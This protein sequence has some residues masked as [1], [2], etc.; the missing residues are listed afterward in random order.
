ME[1]D[2]SRWA[3]CDARAGFP[4]RFPFRLGR[5]SRPLLLLFGVR[6]SNAYVDLDTDIDARFGFYRL[7]TPVSNVTRYRIEGP[8]HWLTA[9][10]V[11]RGIRHGDIS[12]GGTH[13]G[14]FRLD[15]RD[16]VRW[17]LLRVPALYVTVEDTDGFAKALRER[18]IPG[19]DARRNKF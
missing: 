17:G 5:R 15:F 19:V 10:G 8:W 4:M 6:Q 13:R 18:G 2:D 9:I 12:F 3:L 7:R 14:G 11:R 1:I 16:R